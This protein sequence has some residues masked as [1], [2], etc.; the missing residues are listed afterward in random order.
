MN[1]KKMLGIFAHPDDES[2]GPG[3]T[4]ARYAR[5][6]VEVHVAIA[7]DDGPAIGMTLVDWWDVTPDEPNAMVMRD[8]D[9]D[10]FFALLVERIGRLER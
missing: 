2:F 3:G 4:L 9:A 10:R 5:A 6:G 7:T 8:I 1:T